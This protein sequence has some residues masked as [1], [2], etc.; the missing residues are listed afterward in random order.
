[1]IDGATV[2]SLRL[3]ERCCGGGGGGS[4]RR[5]H[6][7]R[8]YAVPPAWWCRHWRRHG[9]RIAGNGNGSDVIA[10]LCREHHRNRTPPAAAVA[11][12]R[13]RRRRAHCRRV[14]SWRES[15]LRRAPREED[16]R[17]AT[18][19]VC[20][21]TPRASSRVKRDTYIVHV[22]VH[23]YSG[24]VRASVCRVARLRHRV[25]LDTRT[26]EESKGRVSCVRRPIR[27][28]LALSSLLAVAFPPPSLARSLLSPL[29][30]FL[31]PVRVCDG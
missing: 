5:C 28:V 29:S 10:F 3:L 14:N 13:L 8:R 2:A 9:R 25:A 12:R 11:A 7:R 1:M 19:P 15:S 18:S 6:R 22:H 27:F 31:S 17:D 16:F 30:L 20:I 4:G 21:Y 26:A 23:P 24:R